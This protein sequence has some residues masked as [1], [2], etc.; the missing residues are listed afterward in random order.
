MLL[1]DAQKLA[2]ELMDKHELTHWRFEFDKATRR[3][4]ATHYGLRM[5]TLSKALVQLNDEAQ[6]K[7]TILHEIAHAICGH[8]N[9][10]N[11]VWRQ[12]ARVIGCNG[13]RTYN[14][15]EVVTPPKPFKG[16]CPNCSRVI[17]ARRRSSIACGRCCREHNNN[18]Y[19]DEY[20]IKWERV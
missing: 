14:S 19:T 2:R 7:D 16:T 15:N 12:T 3:F 10:H 6:V 4:G 8:A 1:S 11:E 9:G 17:E 20:K 18:R 13:S 5:I